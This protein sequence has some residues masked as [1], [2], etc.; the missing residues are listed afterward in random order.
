M[1]SDHLFVLQM[2][3][4]CYYTAWQCMRL[5]TCQAAWT[6]SNGWLAEVSDS[7]TGLTGQTGQAVHLHTLKPKA[8]SVSNFGRRCRLV[9][10][11]LEPMFVRL[12]LRSPL[13]REGVA[14]SRIEVFVRS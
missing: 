12:R 8:E 2:R 10:G 9:P 3:I 14:L 13:G 6:H 4:F 1:L 11:G 7:L 5:S